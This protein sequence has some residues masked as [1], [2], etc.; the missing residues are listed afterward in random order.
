MPNDI[1]EAELDALLLLAQTVPKGPWKTYTNPMRDDGWLF[2][3]QECEATSIDVMN[4]VRSDGKQ[5]WSMRSIEEPEVARFIVAARNSI[6]RL[7]GALRERG[8]G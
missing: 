8:A 3:G 4:R 5:L 2:V 6:E 7:V 1:T